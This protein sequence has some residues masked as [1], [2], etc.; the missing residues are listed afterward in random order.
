MTV[1]MVL[2]AKAK[3]SKGIHFCS[4]NINRCVY[5][6]LIALDLMPEAAVRVVDMK[7]PWKH[8]PT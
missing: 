1:I 4:H 7:C 3:V 8:E 5:R 2:K 6:L